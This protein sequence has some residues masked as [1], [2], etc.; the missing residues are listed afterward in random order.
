MIHKNDFVYFKDL[1]VELQNIFQEAFYSVCPKELEEYDEEH[2]PYRVMSY[3]KSI[4]VVPSMK[5][6]VEVLGMAYFFE[7]EEQMNDELFDYKR[8][9]VDCDSD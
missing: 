2:S 7:C 1:P 8:S 6:Y 4:R 3:D 9:W 5:D